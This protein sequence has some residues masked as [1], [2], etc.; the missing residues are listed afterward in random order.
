MRRRVWVFVAAAWVAGCGPVPDNRFSQVQSLTADRL[1]QRVQWNGHTADD[2]EVERAID[3]L[4]ARPLTVE[5][6]VQVALLNNHKLQATFEDL[7]IA[8]ADLVQAGLLK[9]PVLDLNVRFPDRKPFK[10]YLDFAAAENLLDI[11]L[12]PARKKIAAGQLAEAEANVAH[13]V[14]SLAG[15]TA[16]AFY[17]WQGAQQMVELRQSIADASSA[18]LD[19]AQRLREAGNTTELDYLSERAQAARA[20]VELAAAQSEAADNRERLNALMGVWGARIGWGAPARLPKL[21]AGDVPA[22]GLEA[23]AIQQRQDLAAAREEILTQSRIYGFTV[24][25][26]F[27]ADADAGIEAERET[28]GQWRIGPTIALPVP[29][30]DQGQAAIARAAAIVRQSRQK[31]VALAVEIRSQVRAARTRM[32]NARQAAVMYHDD[33]LPTQ[34]RLLEQT[35]LR[36]NGMLVG[37]FQLLQAKRDQIDAAAQY[38]QSLRT[39]W[40]ARAELERAVGGRLPAGVPA[41]TRTTPSDMNGE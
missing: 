12:I 21:P 20:K 6:A 22:D 4:L 33:I 30:F 35:Q 34:T 31:Y 16:S 23:L 5:A 41:T 19:A 14:F 36:Y 15:E 32:L 38:V 13:D 24:D 37:V 11:F 40:M 7:G 10:T 17:A 8:Q 2:R 25:T 39:Y 1:G 29:L 26:R 3:G 9:N 27:F 18:S 28:D